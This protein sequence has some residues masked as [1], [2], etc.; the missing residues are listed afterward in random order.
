MLP[1]RS[2]RS[3]AK[4]KKYVSIFLIAPRFEIVGVHESALFNWIACEVSVGITE[5]KVMAYST[6]PQL[7]FDLVLL[8]QLQ[9]IYL[10]VQID[11]LRSSYLAGALN[12]IP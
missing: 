12:C 9:S 2:S 3:V 11:Y 7:C 6:R 4:P 1:G 5:R 10:V 8:F